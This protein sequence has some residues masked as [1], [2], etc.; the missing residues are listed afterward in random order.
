[1]SARPSMPSDEHMIDVVCD[2][3]EGSGDEYEWVEG[4]DEFGLREE[5]WC[6]TNRPCRECEGRGYVWVPTEEL[7]KEDVL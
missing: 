4:I 1:M 2:A 3:C 5:G 6:R 7:T